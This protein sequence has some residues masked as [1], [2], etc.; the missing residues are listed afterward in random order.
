ML[1]YTE[2]KTVEQL[3][4]ETA[5]RHFTVKCG[6]KSHQMRHVEYLAW[7][8]LDVPV[9]FKQLNALIDLILREIEETSE[10]QKILIHCGQGHGRTGT[11]LAILN[12]ILVLRGQ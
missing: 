8:D 12:S 11:L 3:G 10:D 9:E 1:N 6:D 4:E 2:G 7:P 5:I